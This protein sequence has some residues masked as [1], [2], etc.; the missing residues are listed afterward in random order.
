MLVFIIVYDE[1]VCDGYWVSVVFF[2]LLSDYLDGHIMLVYI[3]P[4]SVSM[5]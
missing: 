4:M 3:V 1:L 2:Y 5:F